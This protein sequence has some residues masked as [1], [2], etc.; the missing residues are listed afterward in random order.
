M[1]DDFH[2]LLS[3]GRP[4]TYVFTKAI[5]EHIVAKLGSPNGDGRRIPVALIRPSIVLPAVAEPVP[6]WVDS[7]NGPLSLLVLSST[8]ILVTSDY[9]YT[10]KPDTISVDHLANFMLCAAWFQCR[11]GVRISSDSGVS[12]AG[13]VFIS[14]NG[15]LDTVSDAMNTDDCRTDTKDNLDTNIGDCN[16]TVVLKSKTANGISGCTIFNMTSAGLNENLFTVHDLLTTGI[17]TC[18]SCPTRLSIRPNRV[19]GK[20][21]HKPA[22]LFATEKFVYHVLYALLIDMI[23]RLIGYKPM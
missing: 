6:G 7:I 15:V 23:L 3:Q 21:N 17:Q 19:P 4:N 12:V 2:D 22:W 16:N 20:N 8:G 9:D 18:L 14:E 11:N 13:D 10:I 1:L 5:A